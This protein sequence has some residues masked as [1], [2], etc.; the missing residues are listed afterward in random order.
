VSL[1]AGTRLGPY[2]VMP[3]V[4][5]S[6]DPDDEYFSDG[7]T[8]ELIG[9]PESYHMYSHFL[10]PAGRVQ[11]SLAASRRALEL[12]PLS[13]SMVAHVGWH[14]VFCGNFEDSIPYSRAAIDMDP[15]FFAARIH[16]GMALEQVGRVEEAIE[17]FRKAGEISA[18]TSEALASLAH[19]CAVA[20]R[21][22]EARQIAKALDERA[23]GRFVSPFDRA[24]IFAGLGERENSCAWLE[25]AAEDRL[26]SIVE[27]R[28]D[29][30]LASLRE[31][32]RFAAL[33]RRV[34][35]PE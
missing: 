8:E 7:M 5:M 27:M 23:A 26:P 28:V 14:N 32:P 20:G 10:V 34:G 25:R 2:A 17:E 16:L 9:Y 29:P 12:D 35:L 1:S 24:I 19:A 6:P 4:N 31:E 18:E 33:A 13:V 21:T 11:E 30:R 22:D 15:T 3:F